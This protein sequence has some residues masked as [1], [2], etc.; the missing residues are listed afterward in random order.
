[1]GFAT[2]QEVEEIATDLKEWKDE[3][4]LNGDIRKKDIEGKVEDS[5]KE[6]GRRIDKLEGQ[7]TSGFEGLHERITNLA[8]SFSRDIGR[9]EGPTHPPQS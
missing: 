3:I 4:R 7:M 6:L 8:T 9:L 1:V 5:R 2:K